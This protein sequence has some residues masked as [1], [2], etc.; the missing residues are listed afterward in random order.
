MSTV[1]VSKD[2][3]R[4]SRNEDVEAVKYRVNEGY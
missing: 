4:V 2:N 3:K 1:L